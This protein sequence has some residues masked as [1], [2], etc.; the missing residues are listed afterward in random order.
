MRLNARH[1]RIEHAATL[2]Q[3]V[4][5]MR[6][7]EALEYALNAFE[8]LAGHLGESHLLEVGD[9][10]LTRQQSQIFAVLHKN[11]GKAVSLGGLLSV[12]SAGSPTSETSFGSLRA[13]IFFMRR[14][15]AGHFTIQS[16][17]NGGYSMK[18]V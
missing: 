12:M 8:D 2:R 14:K 10:R 9:V 16:I 1:G 7:L 5:D 11:L 13:Q 15:L 6:P 3:A 4:Q 17:Y 18:P